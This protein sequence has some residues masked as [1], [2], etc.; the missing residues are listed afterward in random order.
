MKLD[1]VTIQVADI[2]KSIDFYTRVLGMSVSRRFSPR[3]GME[4]AFMG[5]GAQVELIR[6]PQARSFQGRGISL[7]FHVADIEETLALLKEN[8]VEIVHGPAAMPSGVKLLHA[9]DLNGV[10]LGFVQQEASRS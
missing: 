4:I 7:G 9:R 3:P 2:E 6:D 10:E 8:Q 5:E 1:F